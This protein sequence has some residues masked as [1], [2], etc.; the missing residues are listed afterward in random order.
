ME[1][2]KLWNYSR[3]RVRIVFKDGTVMTGFVDDYVDQ[4]D[5][6]YDYDEI[7]FTSDEGEYLCIGEPEIRLIEII[8]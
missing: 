5:T 1:E 4:E 7:L 6:D 8:E 3:K 2:L